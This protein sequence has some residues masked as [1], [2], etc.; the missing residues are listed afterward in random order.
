MTIGLAVVEMALDILDH[1]DL[2]DLGDEERAVVESDAVR[3]MQP[4]GQ[5]L[6]L[7]LAVPVDDR[8][9]AVEHP[10]ADK[11]G[12]LVVDPHRARTGKPQPIELDVEFLGRCSA[13]TGSLSTAV[14]IGSAATGARL[15]APDPSGIPCVQDGFPGAMTGAGGAAVCA[16]LAGACWAEAGE[17]VAASPPASIASNRVR[18]RMV[19]MAILPGQRCS[20]GPSPAFVE[21]QRQ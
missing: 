21:H 16:G 9:D 2:V 12:A 7:A 6:D 15:A 10:G 19:V 18:D 8:I 3:R 20:Q 14:G 1:R 17:A 11:Y 4:F 13:E 5:D